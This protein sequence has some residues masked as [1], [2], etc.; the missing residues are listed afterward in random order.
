M[1]IANFNLYKAESRRNFL[2]TEARIFKALVSQRQYGYC[3]LLR[4]YK[5]SQDVLTWKKNLSITH[6]RNLTF[7]TQ[8]NF[9]FTAFTTALSLF[10][11]LVHIT[12]NSTQVEQVSSCARMG[13]TIAFISDSLEKQNYTKKKKKKERK[14]KIRRQVRREIFQKIF[15][16]T[17]ETPRQFMRE[18]IMIINIAIQQ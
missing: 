12:K 6:L 14:E 4:S 13:C 1:K 7:F 3:E 9:A 16:I 8:L 18:T 5:V 10:T 15:C 11:I 17:R 2:R